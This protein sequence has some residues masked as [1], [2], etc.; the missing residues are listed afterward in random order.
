[1]RNRLQHAGLNGRRPAVRVPLAV[2]HIQ[3][4]VDFATDHLNWTLIDWEPML[5]NDE[6]RFCIDFTDRRAKVWR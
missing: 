3:A 5:F 1:M 2:R 6:S 4:R